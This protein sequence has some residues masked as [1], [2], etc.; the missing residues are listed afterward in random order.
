MTKQNIFMFKEIENK[1]LF[2]SSLSG[3]IIEGILSIIYKRPFF[4]INNTVMIPLH[5]LIIIL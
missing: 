4:F 2:H 3:T 5:I 1:Y